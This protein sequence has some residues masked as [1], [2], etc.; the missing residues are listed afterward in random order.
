MWAFGKGTHGRLG[1]GDDQNSD[2]PQ[3]IRELEG[4]QI[5]KISAGCRHAAAV[6][7]TGA[8]FTWG[9]NFYEQL[10]LGDSDRDHDAPVLVR[11]DLF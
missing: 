6:S 8:L 4:K 5:T 11:K 2:E 9:F 7:H 10:G 1:L 3:V